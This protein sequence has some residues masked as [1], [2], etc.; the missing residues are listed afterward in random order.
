LAGELK[1]RQLLQQYPHKSGSKENGNHKGDLCVNIA[2][3]T[4]SQI[5]MPFKGAS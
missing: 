1:V 2:P 5:L 3:G 4:A